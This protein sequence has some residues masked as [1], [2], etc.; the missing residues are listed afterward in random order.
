MIELWSS[1]E[2]RGEVGRHV[3]CVGLAVSTGG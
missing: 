1:V 2:L 3:Q